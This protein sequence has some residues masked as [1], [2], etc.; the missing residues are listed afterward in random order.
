PAQAWQGVKHW[1]LHSVILA[2]TFV[3]FPLLGRRA[4]GGGRGRAAS[5]PAPPPP[6]PPP[7]PPISLR[8][9]RRSTPASSREA[10]A[11]QLSALV[12]DF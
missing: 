7:P 12:R 3:V 11:Q 6:P 1:R 2:T 5:R 10:K 4:P 8:P 9:H